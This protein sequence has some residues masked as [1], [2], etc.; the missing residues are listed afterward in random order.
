[1]TEEFLPAFVMSYSDSSFT[2]PHEVALPDDPPDCTGDFTHMGAKYWGFETIRHK[3][4]VLDIDNKRFRFNND[5]HHWLQLGLKAPGKVTRIKVSTRWFTGNQVPEFAIDLLR[6]GK[7]TEVISRSSLAPDAEHEFSIPSTDADACLV[8]CYHEGGIAR[9]NL[10][11]ERLPHNPRDNLL[12]SADITH[13]SNEHYGKPHDAVTGN[14]EVDYM[15]GWESARTGFGEQA[16]FHLKSSAV[17]DEIVVD[18][19]MHRL[20]PPLSCHVFGTL[21]E[22]N[23]IEAVMARAPAWVVE[24]DTGKLVRPSDLSAYMQ[25]KLFLQEPQGGSSFTIRLE[26]LHSD[27][28]HPVVPF[29]ALQADTYHRIKAEQPATVVSHLLYMHYPNGGIHGLKAFGNPVNAD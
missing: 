12:A 13:I 1:M 6:A 21:A 27:I 24:F 8:R 10:F 17:I 19:Y 9:I 2:N 14:R 18:T 5:N 26:N 20:N 22:T 28:W 15:L 29:A 23:D 16:L 4:T 7:A 25:Q 3:A 11:G